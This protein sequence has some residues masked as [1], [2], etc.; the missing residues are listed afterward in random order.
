MT[1]HTRGHHMMTSCSTTAG[2]A[3]RVR[4][5][6]AVFLI[7][8]L[9][10]YGLDSRANTHRSR[11]SC[12][13]TLRLQHSDTPEILP[14]S[15]RRKHLQRKVYL[16]SN[17]LAIKF[18]VGIILINFCNRQGTSGLSISSW[19]LLAKS[20]ILQRN[21]CFWAQMKAQMKPGEC[22]DAE[23]SCFDAEELLCSS[24]TRTENH[25][26]IR[27]MKQKQNFLYI[28]AFASK[29]HVQLQMDFNEIFSKCYGPRKRWFHFVDGSAGISS[30][31]FQRSNANY[32]HKVIL[33]P[34]TTYHFCLYVPTTGGSHNTWGNALVD[35][36][37]RSLSASLVT[38]L[39]SLIASQRP[40]LWTKGTLGAS[41]LPA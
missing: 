10:I 36:G 31:I 26:N 18:L 4:A 32:H 28:K 14:N 24:Q 30:L 19:L 12:G 29:L 8:L 17:Q 16:V 38:Y 22:P 6:T 15:A 35:R 40:R 11:N 34:V 27:D 7:S 37:L 2:F 1:E 33:C 39:S 23:S 25:G 41:L 3:Q 21:K 5:T 9:R 13:G 20:Y